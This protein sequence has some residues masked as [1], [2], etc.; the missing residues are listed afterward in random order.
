MLVGHSPKDGLQQR[1]LR[2]DDAERHAEDRVDACGEDAQHRLP[3]LDH[4]PIV[5]LRPGGLERDLH[6]KLDAFASPDPVPLHLLDALGPVEF[7]QV[8]DQPLGVLRDL[9]EPLWDHLLLDHRIATPAKPADNLLVRQHGHALGAPVDACQ[10]AIGQPAL[11]QPLEDPLRP[12]V[13]VGVARFE[14][15]RPVVADPH[16]FHLPLVGRCVA[17]DHRGRVRLLGDR[18]V[19]GGQTERIE[20]HGVQHAVALH[21]PHAAHQVGADVVAAV[22]HAQPRAAGIGEEVQPVELGSA[23]KLARA[24][25]VGFLPTLTPLGLERG[26]FVT[27]GDGVLDHGE[28][29]FYFPKVQRPCLRV[30]DAEPTR[31]DRNREQRA[32]RARARRRSDPDTC[33]LP[34]RPVCCWRSPRRKH[35]RRCR[36]ST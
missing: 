30:G 26:R 22:A 23:R 12:A 8:V 17:R 25:Q 36:W 13:V 9:E 11:V 33:R 19:F 15:P 6:R 31:G 14:A 5:F 16:K 2:R 20:A 21:G 27:V 35:G 4:E 34:Y 10:P 29:P 18:L 7:V 28:T 24:E 32:K 3:L 1:M